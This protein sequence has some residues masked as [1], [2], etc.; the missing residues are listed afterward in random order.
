[1]LKTPKQLGSTP[2]EVVIAMN[3][4]LWKI[5][6]PELL[7]RLMKCTGTGTPV[8]Q[9]ELAKAAS[10][11]H[12]TIGNLLNGAIEYVPE[13]V[14]NGI[15]DRIGVDLLVLFAPT[16]RAVPAPRTW[17]ALASAVPA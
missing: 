10:A 12:G 16:G 3:E 2:K 11:S 6:D 4:R 15:V 13:A 14:A 1:M 9:R 17:R 5:R 7:E 8:T